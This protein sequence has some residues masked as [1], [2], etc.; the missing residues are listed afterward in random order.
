MS[1][2]RTH[3]RLCAQIKR[4]VSQIVEFEMRD[5]LLRNALPTVMAVKLSIDARY[6][7]VYIAL[8]QGTREEK[9]EVMAAFHRDRGFVR[10]ELAH[11]LSLRYTPQ[12]EFILDETVERAMR[13]D[14]ILSHEHNELS[15]G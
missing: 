10:T 8:G 4:E 7:K 2:G 11:R 1:D 6:A 13:L 3:A 12:L 5:P 15:P 9:M 14:Q